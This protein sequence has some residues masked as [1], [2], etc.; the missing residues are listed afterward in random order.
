MQKQQ[1]EWFL[2]KGFVRNFSKFQ[3]N[4]FFD[5]VKLYIFATLLEM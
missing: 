1:L 2:K 4:I 5:K 3:R